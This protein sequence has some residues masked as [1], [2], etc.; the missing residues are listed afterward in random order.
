MCVYVYRSY[1][2]RVVMRKGDSPLDMRGRCSA[3]QKVHTVVVVVAVEIVVSSIDCAISSYS[4]N[5]I[6]EIVKKVLVAVLYCS[7]WRC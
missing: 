6:A 5:M 4:S 3:G 7:K 1:N 2:Y